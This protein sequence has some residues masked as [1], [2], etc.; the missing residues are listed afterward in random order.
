MYVSHFTLEDFNR[1]S[2]TPFIKA[3]PNTNVLNHLCQ[4]IMPKVEI[5]RHIVNSVRKRDRAYLP[6]HFHV[7]WAMECIGFAF[8]LP[9][10][11][12]SIISTAIE[13]YR[14]WLSIGEGERPTCIEEDEGFYQREI[15]GHLSLLFVE[16]PGDTHKHVELCVEVLVLLREFIRVK[17]IEEDTWKCLLKIMLLLTH[18]LL[19]SITALAQD[20]CPL[21]LKTLFEI[22]LRSNTRDKDLWKELQ[23]CSSSWLHHIWL[24]FQWKAVA[25]GL[26]QRI[27][28]M[29]YGEEPPTLQ[30]HFLKMS[31]PHDEPA[32]TL[33]LHFSLEQSL[34]FWYRFLNLMLL[35]TRDKIPSDPDVHKELVRSVATITD[36]FLEI[37]EKRIIA[38]GMVMPN[39]VT[40]SGPEA[41]AELTRKFQDTH[42]HYLW[43]LSRLPIPS[44]DGLL[45]MFGGWLFFHANAEGSYNEFGRAEAVGALCRIMCKAGGPNKDE[46]LGKF[47]RTIFKCMESSSSSLV[48]MYILKHSPNLL[49]LD[50]R[51]VRILLH[52]EALSKAIM[53]NLTDNNIAP[54]VK[55]PCYYILGTFVAVVQYFNQPAPIIQV[56]NILQKALDHETDSEN[57]HRLV[58]TICVF[59]GSIHSDSELLTNIVVQLVNRLETIDYIQ[60]KKIY[61]DLLDTIS[62]LPFLICYKPITSE[63]LVICIIDKI[64]SY[65]SK[66]IGKSSTEGII[67]S[68]LFSLLH[69]LVCFPNAFMEP[70]IRQN[71]LSVAISAQALDRVKEVAIYVEDFLMN[72]L[73]RSLPPIAYTSLDALEISSSFLT[74]SEVKLPK[75]HFLYNGQ[76]LLTLYDSSQDNPHHEEVLVMMRNSI[77]RYIWKAGLVYKAEN[78][79]TSNTAWKMDVC[80]SRPPPLIPVPDESLSQSLFEDFSE[81]EKNL[82]RNFQ[83]IIKKQEETTKKYESSIQVEYS[84][85]SLAMSPKTVE[86]VPKSYRLLLA[87]L[88]LFQTDHISSL[89]ALNGD[90]VEKI[91]S[92]I[93]KIP[94]KE[95]IICPILYLKTPE[96][97]ESDALSNVDYYS[98]SFQ[99]FL[100]QMGVLLK[101]NHTQFEGFKQVSRFLNKY[102]SALYTSGYYYELISLVPAIIPD[103]SSLTLPDIISHGQVVVLWNQ[104]A[105]DP[106]TAKIPNL[107][108]SHGMKRKTIIILTPLK[109]RLIKVNISPNET[110]QGPLLNDMLVPEYMIGTLLIRTI[111][112]MHGVSMVRVSSRARRIEQLEALAELGRKAEVTKN[113]KLSSILSHAFR[114]TK[115]DQ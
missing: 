106:Y 7:Q 55:R 84:A 56:T 75:R 5:T 72:N 64:C 50:H 54:A 28:A 91:I 82:F 44:A 21:L 3:R 58:W 102:G 4:D 83:E 27:N 51:G 41:L 24:I 107:L 9:I 49:T 16:R 114:L 32:E 1:N 104:R 10:E 101:Q 65:I 85:Q 66:K 29:L 38:K 68:L 13:I 100:P 92:E 22:W 8:S 12:H 97:K 62:T 37:A 61:Q 115:W 81:Q 89:L 88:G 105:N 26:T 67:S 15:I 90:E 94:D 25:H 77:G 79:N 18:P 2:H 23:T 6:T 63:N 40:A 45:N 78:S 87:Q 99:D 95:L 52:K 93:D 43:G 46:F 47:Y 73:G 86:D 36:S 111:I 98:Q 14:D 35:N 108:E 60:E 48:V 42:F 96:S 33:L 112:N 70:T 57:F 59:A 71:T 69:W 30:L 110:Q 74:Y 76:V 17:T 53:N 19:K 31:K 11:H 20:L 39:I 34:Y 109:N 103:T 113:G 80:Q